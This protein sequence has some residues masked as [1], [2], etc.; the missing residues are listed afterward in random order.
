MSFINKYG[1]KWALISS[2]MVGRTDNAIKNQFHSILRRQIKKINLLLQSPLY[3]Q[4]Y[5]W[6]GKDIKFKDTS[7]EDLSK[8]LK[9]GLVGTKELLFKL[10]IEYEDIKVIYK[11]SLEGVDNQIVNW[12]KVEVRKEL[13]I[14][15]ESELMVDQNNR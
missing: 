5:N 15:K 8:F 2:E 13:Q 6:E 10:N 4:L 3:W 14:G 7:I 11:D 9:D 1:N 12:L